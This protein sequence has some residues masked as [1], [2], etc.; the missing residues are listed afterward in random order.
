MVE[1]STKILKSG[2]RVV[3]NQIQLY[4]EYGDDE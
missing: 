1:N 4:I 3:S 2:E